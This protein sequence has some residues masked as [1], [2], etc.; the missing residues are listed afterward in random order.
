MKNYLSKSFLSLVIGYIFLAI[1]HIVWSIIEYGDAESGDIG[2][3]LFWSCFFLIIYYLLFLIL[4]RKL[5]LKLKSRISGSLFILLSGIYAIIGFTILIG[6]AFLMSGNFL[7]VFLDAFVFGI[8]Y[9]IC[10]ENFTQ[11]KTK[12]GNKKFKYWNIIIPVSF[13]VF[14]FFLFPK[15]TPSIAYRFVP[16]YL[17]HQILKETLTNF[18]VGDKL[19]DL[20]E[21]LPGEFDFKN[22]QGQQSGIL[23][24]FQFLI[25][26]NCCEIVEIIVEPRN[27]SQLIMGGED[28]RKPC[29]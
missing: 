18:K 7:G 5:I 1:T 16:Q 23:E 21:A 15:L 17:K 28:W 22:C 4:P 20:Q 14:Y 19:K 27:N 13:I 8:T 26:V 29:N 10:F 2:V 6:W 11:L 12:K 9:G 24:D 25:T 3:V